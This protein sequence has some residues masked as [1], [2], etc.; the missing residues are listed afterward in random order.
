MPVSIHSRR[1]KGEAGAL[2]NPLR[3]W[4]NSQ[5]GRRVQLGRRIDQQQAVAGLALV[6]VGA[7]IQHFYTTSSGHSGHESGGT[8]AIQVHGVDYAKILE[9]CGQFFRLDTFTEA[10]RS[11]VDF[12]QHDAA[13]RLRSNGCAGMN[14]FRSDTG[15]HHTILHQRSRAADNKGSLAPFTVQGK[16]SRN[17]ISG[18]KSCQKRPRCTVCRQHHLA[19][20]QRRVALTAAN[21]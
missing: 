21:F 18:R 15:L 16:G 10:R 2:Q 3:T 11:A 19:G 12:E 5:F 1:R 20:S 4:L 14:P 13:V 6:S 8:A 9:D 7:L 17:L